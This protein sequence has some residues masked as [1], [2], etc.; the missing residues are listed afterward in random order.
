MIIRNEAE[1]FLKLSKIPL[2]DVRSPAE[3]EQGHIPGAINIP[4]FNNEE[5]AEVGTIYKKCSREASVLK[6]LEFSGPKMAGFVRQALKSEKG[7]KLRIHCW[8]GGMRSESMAWLFTTARIEMYLLSGGYKAYRNYIRQ[9]LGHQRPYIVLSGRTGSGKTEILKCL[10]KMRQQVL[11]LEGLAHHKGSAFGAI[12]EKP[13]PTS[14]Q[15]EN[16][17]YQILDYFDDVQSI[18]VE[19]ESRNI[20]RACIPDPMFKNIRNAVV[21]EL[22]MPSALRN[23][24]LVV[25]YAQYPKEQ[26]VNA[27]QRIERKLGGQHA[28]TAIR[29][30]ETDD[31]ETAIDIVL[32][33]YDKTYLYGLSKRDSSK[34]HTLKTN[35]G[36]AQ[37]NALKILD[38][39]KKKNVISS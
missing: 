10:E 16:D 34:I 17:I 5:R 36:D 20:G 33:Y 27:I 18:W 4:L 22:D 6:G 2:I 35:T 12:G 29:A 1:A 13:Q 38:F 31:F 3:Y 37:A 24:R 11:D 26:L 7:H 25:D 32:K 14:E 39:C 15:F 23:K 28:Q 9:Q 30:I 19:D 8:R 21:V